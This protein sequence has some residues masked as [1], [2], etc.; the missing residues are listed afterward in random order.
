VSTALGHVPGEYLLYEIVLVDHA[1]NARE[2]LSTA[3]GGTTD[4]GSLFPST[5]LTLKP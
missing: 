3:F 5:T 2:L 1:G 4:F